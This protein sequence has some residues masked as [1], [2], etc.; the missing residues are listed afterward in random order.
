MLALLLATFA[1]AIAAQRIALAAPLL[2]AGAWWLASRAP[3]RL[4]LAGLAGAVGAFALPFLLGPASPVAAG[5]AEL[6][7][8][9]GV[10]NNGFLATLY[11]D[12][13]ATRPPVGFAAVKGLALLGGDAAQRDYKAQLGWHWFGT[14]TDPNASFLADGF[15]QLGVAGVLVEALL[16]AAALWLLDS[17]AHTRKLPAAFVLAAMAAHVVTLTNGQAPN[18]LLGGGLL[19]SLGLLWLWPAATSAH[20]D[21]A[22]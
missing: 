3:R 13:F 14:E 16:V 9:R 20:T 15:A 22:P 7:L 21:H 18:L 6:V 17:I 5:V 1:Y 8:Y 12:F 4:A 19:C 2:A 11:F 10:L